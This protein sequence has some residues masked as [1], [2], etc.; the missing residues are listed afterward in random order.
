M[1]NMQHN[2]AF[3]PTYGYNLE[4]L[5]QVGVPPE[6]PDF[7]EFWQTTYREARQ[8]PLN[9][10]L[11]KITS[12]DARF[13][14]FEVNYDSLDGLRIGGWLA[15]P[16][17]GEIRRGVVI[18]HGY[19]GRGNLEFQVPVEDAALI[20]PCARG[21]HRS[22]CQEI[23]DT[24][25][26]HVLHGIGARESYSHRGSVADYWGAASVLEEVCP[27][28]RDH[29]FY[30]GAS[31]GGGIGAMMLPWDERFQRAYLGMCRVSAII[32]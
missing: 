3:D 13:E 22:A 27:A 17:N 2:Y 28:V 10:K 16:V 1:G 23:P 8:I 18:G 26:W 15:L 6:P 31:F 14:L 29:L 12:P 4:Q 30:L 20:W 11:V 32:R 19:G 25:A 9:T 21:F 5:L 7:A 24:G